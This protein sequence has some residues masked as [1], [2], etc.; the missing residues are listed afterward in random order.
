MAFTDSN[1]GG[2]LRPEASCSA[3]TGGLLRKIRARGKQGNAKSPICSEGGISINLSISSD[4]NF[5][6]NSEES[7]STMIFFTG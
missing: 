3:I 5:P 7:N 1:S 6:D 2:S 4:V